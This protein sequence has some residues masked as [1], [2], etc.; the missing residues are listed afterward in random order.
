MKIK[1]KPTPGLCHA[2]RCNTQ[3]APGTTLCESHAQAA[4][5]SLAK[6]H[7]ATDL[8]TTVYSAEVTPIRNE[9]LELLEA[10]SNLPLDAQVET[11]TQG[12]VSGLTFLGLAREDARLTHKRLEERR[13]AITRPMLDAKREVDQLF[14]PATDTCTAVIRAC[15]DR[16][17][18]HAHELAAER[19]LALAAVTAAVQSGDTDLVRV[20][21]ARAGA[22]APALPPQVRLYTE[23][24]FV[25]EDLSLVPREWMVLDE[26]RVLAHVRATQ[27]TSPIP[28]I[29]ITRTEKVRTA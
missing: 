9:V 17:E 28:G 8:T 13:T 29:T 12:T 26:A 15:T 25:V 1:A 6:A 27:G 16:M 10:V 19:R 18:K 2:S 23:V 22:L 7:A 14:K 20:E 4:G 11:E 21:H 5:K 3:V 24:G